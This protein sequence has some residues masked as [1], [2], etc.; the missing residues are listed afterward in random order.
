MV[1]HVVGPNFQ[2]RRDCNVED[3]LDELSQAYA[4]ALAEFASC[5]ARRLRLLPISS[6]IF[7]GPFLK[8]MPELTAKAL[9]QGFDMISAGEQDKVLGAD[10]L[11][12]CI[13]SEAELADFEESFRAG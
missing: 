6:S 9:Q 11:E 8:D 10:R 4:S 5:P 12:M 13:F 7:A 2:G 3:A 1:I